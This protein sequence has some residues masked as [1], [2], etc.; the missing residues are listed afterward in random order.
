MSPVSNQNTAL[1]LRG[2]VIKVRRT[3]GNAR[4][5]CSRG[6]LHETWAL[7]YSYQGRTRMIPLRDEDV[8]VAR[9]A[10]QRYKKAMASLEL[11]AIMGIRR[12]HASVKAAKRRAR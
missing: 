11:K 4:C 10:I 2:S 8:A 3:C 12:L 6:H 1:F 9:Q 5:K 7:S